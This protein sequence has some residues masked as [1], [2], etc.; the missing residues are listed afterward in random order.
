MTVA[1]DGYWCEVVARWP[2]MG[3]EWVLGG[4]RAGSPRLALRWLRGQ[5]RR[6]SD[7]L[8]PM[9]GGPFPDS[10]LYGV[11][12]H[13]P[14]PGRTFR[15]WMDDLRS[16]EQ[17][18]A[19]L[20]AGRHISVTA[21]GP[22]PVCDRWDADVHYSL[23]CRPITPGFL[24]DRRSVKPRYAPACQ[25]PAPSGEKPDRSPT[26]A[27][28]Q[29]AGHS[30]MPKQQTGHAGARKTEKPLVDRGFYEC[31]RGELNPHAL[32]GTGT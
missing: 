3:R 22:D 2:E 10:V 30:R 6:L 16:Q 1:H 9:P 8:D 28:R 13:A 12:P 14:N 24:T 25:T 17:Q 11:D 20:V 4:D 27:A 21:G 29:G 5:A 18:L 26:A 23:S 19:A 15:V 7:A 31:A 32:A